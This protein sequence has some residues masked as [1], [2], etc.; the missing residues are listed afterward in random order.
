MHYEDQANVIFYLLSGIAS[1]ILLMG[2]I[3]MVH[4]WRLGK[5]PTLNRNIG[6]SKWIGSILKASIIETQI[7][8]YSV[9]AWLAHIM[10][11]W[12]FV[13]L[14][15]LTSF[16]FVLNWL[17]PSSS[18]FFAYF[19]S[20]SGNLFLAV[21]GDFWGLIML[22]GILMALFRRYILRPEIV[23]TISSD[24]IAIWFLFV[25]TVSGF[26]CEAVRIA[27]Q[28]GSIDA[29][30]SFAVKWVVPLLKD[31]H[32]TSTS[33]TYLFWGHGILSLIFIGYIPFSKF[34]HIFASPLDFAFVTA[35]E[36]YS[37][38]GWIKQR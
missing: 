32:L 11:F 17:L 8:E 30:Y 3:S 18:S 2:L 34:R 1:F 7:L 23:S 5:A 38:L 35:G 12:G 26:L 29:D 15:L 25:L 21:W 6:I 14:F 33:V 16:H 27:V 19:T 31:L 36:R 13:T 24:S 10:I 4:I 9:L 28:P 22:G 20:G 37:K